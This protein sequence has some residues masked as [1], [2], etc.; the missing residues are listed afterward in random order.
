FPIVV[1]A[2]GVILSATFWVVCLGVVPSFRKEFADVGM[3]LPLI[4]VWLI[5]VGI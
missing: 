3:E 1:G 2:F 5:Q 4:T